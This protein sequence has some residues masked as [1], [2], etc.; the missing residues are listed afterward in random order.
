[1]EDEGVASLKEVRNSTGS[2]CRTTFGQQRADN[3]YAR[4]EEPE[5][6]LDQGSAIPAAGNRLSCAPISRSA[7]PPG[8]RA[9]IESGM[10]ILPGV[11]FRLLRDREIRGPGISI[12]GVVFLH[13]LLPEE[14]WK[15]STGIVRCNTP[16]ER[17]LE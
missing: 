9:P 12:L 17:Q 2:S 1:M 15:Q 13:Q 11:I 3:P 8:S 6:D 7:L 16:Q 10:G 4:P 14:A 5:G